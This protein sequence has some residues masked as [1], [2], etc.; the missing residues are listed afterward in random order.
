MTSEALDLYDIALLLNF[1]R[2]TTEPRF[3]HAKLVDIA[4][5]STPFETIQIR[6]PPT[7]DTTQRKHKDGFVFETVE[8]RSAKARALPDLPTTML[9]TPI[10]ANLRD[11]TSKRLETI[12]WQARNHDTCYQCIRLLQHFFELFP[13]DVP[14]RVRTAKGKEFTTPAF[15]RE[16][17]KLTLE[18]PERLTLSCFLPKGPFYT[19][20][21]SP[22]MKHGVL[23]FRSP[24]DE[25]NDSDSVVLDLSSLQFG[26]AGRG[27]GGTFVLEEHDVFM[28]RLGAGRGIATGYTLDMRAHLV[29]IREEAEDRW[30]I[31]V[32]KRAKARWDK[33]GSEI[34]CGHCGAPNP[35]LKRCAA[36]HE[37][38]YCNA[39]HQKAAWVYHKKWCVG[40]KKKTGEKSS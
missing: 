31:E 29:Q 15:A 17:L 37:I 12:F 20:G 26:D 8:P 16:I 1:E 22:T 5:A 38:G 3:R 4:S 39:E 11:L 18:A 13:T 9:C 33:R 28:A 2:A 25:D 14:V 30:L 23:S 35:A 40:A 34:W 21:E 6:D 27:T 10:P 7:W 24:D 19:H 36:C 32:A